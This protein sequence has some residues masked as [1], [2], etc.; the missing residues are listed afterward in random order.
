[1]ATFLTDGNDIWHGFDQPYQKVYAKGGNDILYGGQS[2]NY[3]Y[4]QAGND[5]L[6]GGA[7]WDY[8]NGGT[9]NDTMRGGG[10]SDEY[11]VDSINDVVVENTDEGDWD[12]IYSTV[13]YTL[14]AN[15]EELS[16]EDGRALVNGVWVT[17]P[18]NI[19][20]TG[21]ALDNSLDGNSGNNVLSGLLG[22]DSLYGD[23]GN[24]T[25]Y[26]GQGD[27]SLYGD[28][29]NDAMYG[30]QGNDSY[31]VDTI[32]DKVIEYANAGYDSVSSEISYTLVA[33]LEFLSLED[34]YDY[35]AGE[36]DWLVTPT[37]INGTGNSL[38]NR[39]YGSMGNNILTGLG[40]NDDLDGQAGNDTL[41]GGLGND[42][43]R[44]DS[45]GDVVTE[46]ANQGYDSV[47]SSVSYTLGANLESLALFRPEGIVG[48]TNT[49]TMP[50]L[51]LNGTGNSLANCLN[52]NE[53]NN[54]LNGLAGT[55]SLYGGAGNDTLNG[56]AGMDFLFGQAGDD[57]YYVDA[58][59]DLVAETDY[60]GVTDMGGAD[61]ICSTI[62]YALGN[63]LEKLTL[64]GSAAINGVGNALNNVLIGNGAANILNG[65]TGNDVLAGGAG[66]DGFLFNTALN[67]TTNKDTITDYTVADDTIRLENA[68]FG[69][70]TTTGV[71]NAANFRAVA[72]GAAGDA[73]DCI[74]YNT[75]TG[76]LSYDLDGNGAG[77]AVQFA[78]LSSKPA[79][80]AGEF[81]VV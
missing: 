74:L 52:G 32:A 33:N 61:K 2:S 65:S 70:L 35:S 60:D 19:N 8:L 1:M 73:D 24:D 55:D 15:I 31:S 7:Q 13:T 26:G 29:G 57:T 28:A 9:G 44:V 10:E 30:G 43:Y 68:I 47:M 72:G 20:G 34:K 46:L 39:L 53:D 27:D 63:F 22:D 42:S 71:L 25:M 64:I 76:A 6:I 40:G 58:V 12:S 3:L 23:A 80:T 69:K 66:Q 45:L 56:G 59:G 54:I 21:N 81:L 37:N 5:T 79:L 14:P 48:G 4:G 16:L 77:V 67:A 75:T 51:V 17:Q 62:S 36:G 11:Y 38:N 41:I 78:T 50:A 49:P 18:L